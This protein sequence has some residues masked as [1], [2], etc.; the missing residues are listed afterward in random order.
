MAFFTFLYKKLKIKLNKNLNILYNFIRIEGN[1]LNI[2]DYIKIIGASFFMFILLTVCG[3][4][5]LIAI[6]IA[7][8]ICYFLRLSIVKSEI[9]SDVKKQIKFNQIY[10][11]EIEKIEQK[12]DK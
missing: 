4:N 9:K 2:K 3:M 12:N 5:H 7:I 6:I 11:K 8:I 1:M 10:E